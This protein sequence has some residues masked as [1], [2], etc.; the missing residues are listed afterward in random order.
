MHFYQSERTAVLID[1]ANLYQTGRALGLDSEWGIGSLRLTLG[2]SNDETN[3][4][5]V[6]TVLPYII[7]ELREG[8]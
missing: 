5:R 7:E 6:V 3:L 4:K 2:R 1:G 8:R